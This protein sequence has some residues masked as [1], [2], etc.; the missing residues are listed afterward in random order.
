MS[1]NLPVNAGISSISTTGLDDFDSLIAEYPQA[2]CPVRHHF[3]PGIYI[4]EVLIPAGTLILGHRHKN[5]HTNILVKGRIKFLND[6]GNVIELAGPSVIISASGR[7]LAFAM[8]DTVWQNVYATEE[9]DVAKL[10]EQLL[11]KSATWLECKAKMFQLESHLHEEDRVDFLKAIAEYGMDADYV[12]EMSVNE[13]DMCPLPDEI[14]PKALLRPSPIHG[15]GMFAPSPISKGTIIGPARIDGKRTPF[16]R[17]LN[18]AK[19]PN[20]CFVYDEEQKTIQVLAIRDI[21]GCHGGDDGE[22]ITV[23]Y[24][25]A[26][27]LTLNIN[28]S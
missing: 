13:S 24:R 20:A 23:C 2:E 26:L 6:D 1:D 15:V 25:Q 21:Y 10:E 8:E 4:R 12:H 19:S 22:E 3:G 5:P 28:K 27:N 11:D 18:H 17:Y 16:G 7:K 14:T 9:R